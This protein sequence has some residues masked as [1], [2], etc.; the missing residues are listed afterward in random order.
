MGGGERIGLHRRM[1]MAKGF[2]NLGGCSGKRGPFGPS[3]CS[4]RKSW[5]GDGFNG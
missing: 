4:K 2:G 1:K 3:P 5:D